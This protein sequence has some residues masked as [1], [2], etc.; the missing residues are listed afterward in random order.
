MR[1]YT[2]RGVVAAGVVALT[3]SLFG[4][5]ALGQSP[6]P[7]PPPSF[8]ITLSFQGAAVD[9]TKDAAEAAAVA[10]A[11]ADKAAFEEQT[12]ATCVDKS[13]EVH[14]QEVAEDQH[15]A[16]ANTIALCTVPVP[17]RG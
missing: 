14:S 8:E 15:L 2:A 6:P 1:N 13:T 16:F 17:D 4:A 7:E 11:A 9:E 12:G 3:I 5:T 10:K